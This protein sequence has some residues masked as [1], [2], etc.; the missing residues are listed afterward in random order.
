MTDSTDAYAVILVASYGD[1]SVTA[2]LDSGDSIEETVVVDGR[3]GLRQMKL[4]GSTLYIVEAGNSAVTTMDFKSGEFSTVVS[5]LTSPNDIAV[6]GEG[7]LLIADDV[8]NALLMTEVASLPIDE[9]STLPHFVGANATRC[10]TIRDL[11]VNPYNMAES[12]GPS[13]AS[14]VLSPENVGI[15]SVAV[16]G[17]VASALV[18][19]RQVKRAPY[20]AISPV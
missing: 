18:A 5:S 8:D 7:E 2:L 4:V 6:T 16:L 1:G 13:A 14:F 3:S 12:E 17:A 9:G 15:G 11:S 20:Q 19:Y 10:V